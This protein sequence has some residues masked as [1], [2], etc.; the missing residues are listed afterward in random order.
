[1]WSRRLDS[2]L[3]NRTFVSDPRSREPKYQY[4][5]GPFAAVQILLV[6]D[7]GMLLQLVEV[8]APLL[9]RQY[10]YVLRVVVGGERCRL[11]T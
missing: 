8:E 7:E 9:V 11:V 5:A 1:M 10:V 3:L 4:A 6:R 2:N